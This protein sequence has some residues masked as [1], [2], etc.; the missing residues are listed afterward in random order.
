MKIRNNNKA[1]TLVEVMV[2]AALTSL[3]LTGVIH[4]IRQGSDTMDASVWYKDN[5]TKIQI[6][7]NRISEDLYKASNLREY[8]VDPTTKMDIVKETEHPFSYIRGSIQETITDPDTDTEINSNVIP[9]VVSKNR[10]T[11]PERKIFSFIINSLGSSRPG[12]SS[13]TYSMIVNVY[14]KGGDLLYER[15][16]FGPSPPSTVDDFEFHKRVIL[17][18]VDYIY[19][20]HRN[21]TSKLDPTI[22]EGSV[23]KLII[24]L[25]DFN[26]NKIRA[27]IRTLSLNR[28]VKINVEAVQVNNL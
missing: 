15:K 14:L 23:I 5:L 16:W 3:V 13:P 20:D 27:K 10:E 17:Q 11:D 8:E 24:K 1:F 6:S 25:K 9:G 21:F 2:V 4:M 12:S 22:V 26:T 7:M 18:N 19:I 28:S